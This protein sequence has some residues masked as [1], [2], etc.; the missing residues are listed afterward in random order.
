T[1]HVTIVRRDN[2]RIEKRYGSPAQ[3]EGG[4]VRLPAGADVRPG[5]DL[6]YRLL[7]DELRRMTVLDAFYSYMSGV[8]HEDDHIEL[9]S[10]PAD[11]IAV[12][13][14]AMPVLHSALSRAAR[15][16]EGGQMLQA[17]C[18]ALWLVEERV[19]SLTASE[20]SGAALMESVFGAIPPQL[21]ITTTT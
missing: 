9:T 7:N 6:E 17:V 12:P 11:R 16:A 19:Q 14:L 8:S 13:Q 18:E 21:D 3:V 4:I 20:R 15:L 2:E 5:D 10:V 1:S